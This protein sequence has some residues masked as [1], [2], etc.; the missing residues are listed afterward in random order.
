MK[1]NTVL[2]I[3]LAMFIVVGTA[4]AQDK[5]FRGTTDQDWSK[6]SNWSDSSCTGTTGATLPGATDDVAICDGVTCDL[7]SGRTIGKV[8]VQGAGIL[9][10]GANTLTISEAGGL[11]LSD[12]LAVLNIGTGAVACTADSTGTK[13][14]IDGTLNLTDASSDLQFTTN[15]AEV[16]GS[17]SIVGQDDEA[18]ISIASGKTLTNSLATTNKGIV[19]TLEISGDGNFTNHGIV[20]ANGG[21]LLLIDITG[22][23]SDNASASWK[24][25]SAGSLLEFTD[26]LDDHTTSISIYG[27]FQISHANAEIQID[28]MDNLTSAFTTTGHLDMSAGLFDLN[29]SVTMGS[30]GNTMNVTGGTID[31]AAGMVFT[32]N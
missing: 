26:S 7:D 18:A 15:S 23:L 4:N 16:T 25:T 21:D 14:T 27:D 31:L 2:T 3:A 6:T 13:H 9:N 1:L 24:A 10:T 17:G 28:Q 11:K 22:T 20:N 12:A 8:D 29:E 32:H 19:G 30:A 5:Y